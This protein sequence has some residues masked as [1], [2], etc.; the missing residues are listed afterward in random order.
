[1]RKFYQAALAIA[2]LA[3]SVATARAADIVTPEVYDWSGFYIGGNVGYAFGGDDEVGLGPEG[4]GKVGDLQLEGVFGGGQVGVN[5]Q[6]NRWL[7]GLEADIQI[8]DINDSESGTKIDDPGGDLADFDSKDNIDWFSTIRGRAGF[9]MNRLLIYG[10]GGLAIGGINYKVS[11]TEPDEDEHAH[12]NDNY[13][14]LG[15]TA[16]AGAEWAFSE[17]LSA[18]VEYMYVNFGE[19]TIHASGQDAEEYD[20]DTHATPDFHS[21]RFGLNYHF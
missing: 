13:T 19:R 3:T 7:L 16:G 8:A 11:L 21:V 15:W 5:W 6:R 14:E 17:K 9:A 12:W 18:K 10:T 4:P 2:A 20:F 1:M